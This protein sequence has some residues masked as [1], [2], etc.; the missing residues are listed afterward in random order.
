[1]KRSRLGP[2]SATAVVLIFLMFIGSSVAVLALGIRAQGALAI[3]SERSF[4]ER[5]SLSYIA[6]KLRQNDGA[7]EIYV[8]DFNGSS[9]FF[10]ESTLE[11]VRYVSVLYC[12]NGYLRELFFE[13]GTNFSREDG[14]PLIGIDE[15]TFSEPKKGLIRIEM[16]NENHKRTVMVMFLQSGGEV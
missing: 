15:I 16:I 3:S 11:G 4:D 9:A 7:G 10:I 5:T 6:E 1:M 13:K 8:G 2:V 12:Y 14:T